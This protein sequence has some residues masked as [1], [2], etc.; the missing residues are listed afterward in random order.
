LFLTMLAATAPAA[1]EV[2]SRP[3]ERRV[4]AGGRLIWDTSDELDLL[5]DLWADVTLPVGERHSV[6]LAV[7]TRTEIER[8]SSDLTFDVRALDYLLAAGWRGASLWKRGGP[9]SVFAAQRGKRAV[10]ADG[11]AWVRYVGLR[12]E[13]AGFRRYAPDGGQSARIEWAA[14]AGPVLDER[15]IDGELVAHGATRIRFTRAADGPASRWSADLSVDGLL[16]DGRF[17]A[18]VAVGPRY[19]LPAGEGLRASLFLH[20]LRSRNPLG[21]GHSGVLLGFEYSEGIA[22]RGPR[23]GAPRIE[24]TLS[25]GGGEDGRAAGGI[26]LRFVSPPFGPELQFAISVDANVLSA[27]DTR[28]LFYLYHV[29][30]ERPLG[31]STAGLYFYH[32]SNHQLAPNDLVTSINVLETGVE[33]EGWR[34]P[35]RRE[36]SGRLGRLD[37]RA[38]IGYLLDSEFGLNRRFNAFGGLRWTIRGAGVMP[39]LTVVAEVGDVD[40]HSLALGVSPSPNLDLQIQYM[41]D[42]QLF[43]VDDTALLL[44]ARYGF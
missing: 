21:L 26:D 35:G 15:Q 37:G 19:T 38:R 24:G 6:F 22:G 23:P 39:F 20:Y 31:R 27:D 16:T 33:T 7:V 12:V 4:H 36:I 11:E 29:G 17:E 30:L 28:D 25:A 42:E 13:S 18:D 5:G 43:S 40:R 44:V 1:E 3:A 14:A 9:T 10:D 32:R 8:A 41:D 2:E 34:R